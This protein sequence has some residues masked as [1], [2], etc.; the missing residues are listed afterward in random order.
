MS[1]RFADTQSEAARVFYDKFGK[2]EPEE[3]NDV[4]KDLREVGFRPNEEFYA[5]V[6]RLYTQKQNE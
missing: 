2:L 4:M 3:F 6:R 5:V 1:I